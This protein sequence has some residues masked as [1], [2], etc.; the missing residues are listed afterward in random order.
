[1]CIYVAHSWLSSDCIILARFFIRGCRTILRE[2]FKLYFLLIKKIHRTT[3]TSE[4]L[5]ENSYMGPMVPKNLWQYI[6]LNP[7][8][9]MAMGHLE[10]RL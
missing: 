1:M 4:T 6:N 9:Y 7:P 2:K 8:L 10:V 5:T 3:Y